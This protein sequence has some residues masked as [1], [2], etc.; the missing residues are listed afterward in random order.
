MS[1]RPRPRSARASVL[2]GPPPWRGAG[3]PAGRSNC[4]CPGWWL[5]WSEPAKNGRAAPFCSVCGSRAQSRRRLDGA[6]ATLRHQVELLREISRRQTEECQSRS[7]ERGRLTVD[8]G[9]RERPRSSSRQRR[10]TPSRT[11]R[12]HAAQAPTANV[13]GDLQQQAAAETAEIERLRGELR[14]WRG[15]HSCREAVESGRVDP[16]ELHRGEVRVEAERSQW[17]GEKRRLEAVLADTR[18]QV[19][20]MT[21]GRE[22]AGH[23]SQSAA[24]AEAEQLRAEA[25]A[26]RGAAAGARERLALAWR[27]LEDE[28]QRRAQQD[29]LDEQEARRVNEDLELTE[30]RL[31]VEKELKVAQQTQLTSVNSAAEA[32][33]EQLRRVQVE[34]VELRASLDH[35]R[36]TLRRLQH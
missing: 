29:A 10:A 22:A 25:G 11:L 26:A 23:A 28:R 24:R 19:R 7:A 2:P 4:D 31:E 18:E 34:A 3:V 33:K 30:R 35:N 17:E 14:V 12:L 36:D 15:D 6:N 20:L 27:E 1:A 9:D 13:R 16:E 8:S 32:L 5:H 21:R